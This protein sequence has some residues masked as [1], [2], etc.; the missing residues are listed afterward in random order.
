MVARV[1]TCEQTLWWPVCVHVSRRYVG[2][3]VFM[4]A[5]VMVAR[6]CSCE[7]TLRWPVCVHVSRRY[8]G[9]CVFV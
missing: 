6:V 8:G 3:C 7:Q 2:L 9:P 1:C 5:D 4:F